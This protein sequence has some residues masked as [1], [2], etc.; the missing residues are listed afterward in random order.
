M[1]LTQ[2]ITLLALA[3]KTASGN[4]PIVDL[5]QFTT[6]RLTLGV[7]AASGSGALAL[8]VTVMTSEDQIVWTP[9]G[10]FPVMTAPGTQYLPLL[11]ASQYIQATWTMVDAG[12]PPVPSFTF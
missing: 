8:T 6:A 3:A 5:A 7:T 4:G 9:L 11:G 12:D 10:V 2:A 1:A